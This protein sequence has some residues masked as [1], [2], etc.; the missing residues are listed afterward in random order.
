MHMYVCVFSCIWQPTCPLWW[1][2]WLNCQACQVP[3]VQS[4]CH[5]TPPAACQKLIVLI[6]KR[7][8]CN[9]A[10]RGDPPTQMKGLRFVLC[11]GL[12][13]NRR[14][15][16]P[17]GQEGRTAALWLE[18]RRWGT[19]TG[20]SIHWVFPDF[21]IWRLKKIL[22]VFHLVSAVNNMAI[23][24]YIKSCA[25]KVSVVLC[26]AVIQYQG[27]KLVRHSPKGWQSPDHF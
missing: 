25:T 5:V 12:A 19:R 18:R 1:Q 24:L 13:G 8:S 2:T 4:W 16:W 22:K 10:L 23:D 14:V 3:S 27:M 17:A 7:Q 26:Y 6:G 9:K 21:R 15:R 11:Q 20:G